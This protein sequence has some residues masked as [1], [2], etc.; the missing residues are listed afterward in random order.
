V[1]FGGG[2]EAAATRAHEGETNVQATRMG[3]RRPHRS[4]TRSQI[5]ALLIPALIVAVWAWA[6][7]SFVEEER[8]MPA[9]RRTMPLTGTIAAIADCGRGLVEL[10]TLRIRWSPA[11]ADLPAPLPVEVQGTAA[12][13]ASLERFLDR[14]RAHAFLGHVGSP[15]SVGAAGVEFEVRLGPSED[16]PESAVPQLDRPLTAMAEAT[17]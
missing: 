7:P 15:W 5:A 9:P 1:N 2:P 10:R 6:R 4:A 14:L 8:P 17:R 16:S 11:A 3:T 13:R 12:D